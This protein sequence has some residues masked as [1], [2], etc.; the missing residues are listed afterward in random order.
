[1]I[2]EIFADDF[3]EIEDLVDEYASSGEGMFAPGTLL[4]DRLRKSLSEQTIGVFASYESDQII[5]FSVVGLKS[6]GISILHINE[7][8]TNPLQARKELFD[9]GFEK[10]SNDL[11]IIRIGSR[12]VPEDLSEYVIS[13]G[14]VRYDR[15]HMTLSREKIASFSKPEL[16]DDYGYEVYTNKMKDDVAKLIYEANIGNID[17][18]VFPNFF[19]TLD[20]VKSLIDSIENDV[21]GQYLEGYSFVLQKS[22]MPVGVIFLTKTDDETGYIPDICIHKDERRRGLARAIQ[23]YSFQKMIEGNVEIQK[24]NL[25]VTMDNPAR[26]LYESLG[27]EDVGIYAVYMWNKSS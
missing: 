26:H 6:G 11:P 20:S 16:A 14:F 15:K 24:I 22:G 7:S 13:R 5:G 21:Y 9:V 23:I 12:C 27:F 3:H 19:S 8:A 25:D 18:N 1:M 17:V 4:K 10:L 2:Q